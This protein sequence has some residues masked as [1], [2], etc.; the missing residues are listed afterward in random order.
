MQI[1]KK[2]QFDYQRKVAAYVNDTESDFVQEFE[3]THSSH[4]MERAAQRGIN[5]LRLTLALVHG[6]SIRKQGYEFCILGVD[7]IPDEF[8]KFKAQ[9]KNTV[10]VMDGD[11]DTLVTCYRSKDPY[12]H[13]RK[14]SKFLSTPKMAA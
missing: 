4:S 9:L 5:N 10:V 6:I 11:S 8:L 1:I 3:F 7:R 14:K 13:I 12:K 2:S